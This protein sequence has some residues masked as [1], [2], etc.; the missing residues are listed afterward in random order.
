MNKK[1]SLKRSKPIKQLLYFTWTQSNHNND[2][3]ET[4]EE[5]NSE[6]AKRKK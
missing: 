4:E 3:I 5:H 6:Y 2:D 1:L